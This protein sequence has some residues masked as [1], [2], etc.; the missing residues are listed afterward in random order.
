MQG[1]LQFEVVMQEHR[2][3]ACVAGQLNAWESFWNL[4]TLAVTANLL[5]LIEKWKKIKRSEDE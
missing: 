2:Q 4:K 3:R 5:E 1:E